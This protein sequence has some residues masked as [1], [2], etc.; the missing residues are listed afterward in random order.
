MLSE[1]YKQDFLVKSLDQAEHQVSFLENSLR[2]VHEEFLEDVSGWRADVHAEGVAM[3]IEIAKYSFRLAYSDVNL[4]AYWLMHFG[5]E[6][7][8]AEYAQYELVLD[9]LISRYLACKKHYAQ[10]VQLRINFR[11]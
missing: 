11:R 7:D 8:T 3:D 1:N 5:D 6:L 10:D 9:T 2:T 4:A